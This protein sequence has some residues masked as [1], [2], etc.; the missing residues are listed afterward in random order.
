MDSINK[1]T[2]RDIAAPDAPAWRRLWAYYLAFYKTSVPAAVTDATWARMLDPASSLFGRAATRDGAMI[3]FA[4]ALV[5]EGTWTAAPVCYLEDLYVD[6]AARGGGVGKALL[7]DLV[8]SARAHG[9]SRLYWHTA[10][11]NATARGLYDQ[12]CLADDHVRYRMKLD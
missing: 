6:P 3:G 11:S 1:P 9:W 2:I 8:D 4:I 5:H 7:Q 10:E 12:F